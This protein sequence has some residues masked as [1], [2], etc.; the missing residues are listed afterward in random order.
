VVLPS[1]LDIKPDTVDVAVTVAGVDR[2][3]GTSS[4][5]PPQAARLERNKD[6]T[7]TEGVR[8]GAGV[9]GMVVGS[10]RRKRVGNEPGRR[11][12]SGCGKL[13]LAAHQGQQCGDIRVIH[14]DLGVVACRLEQST[15][16]K[17]NWT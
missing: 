17:C 1:P 15:A 16:E 9:K 12:W 5:P 11:L 8:D 3:P 6:K 2:S 13:D 10:R 7:I 14:R 4:L